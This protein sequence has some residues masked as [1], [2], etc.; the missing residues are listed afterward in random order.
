MTP[1]KQS[2]GGTLMIDRSFPG[3]GRLHRASG[4]TKPASFRAFND[5]LT[6]MGTDPMG[7][8]WIR[9]MQQGT[10]H[11]L[12]VWA[13]YRKNEWQHGPEKAIVGEPLVKAI[14]QW[15]EDTKS[16]VSDDTYRV[17]KELATKVAANSRAG[18]TVGEVVDVMARIKT[19]MLATPASFNILRNYARAFLRDTVGERH[20][21]Y[22]DLKFDV[23]P[24]E[25]PQHALKKERKRHALTPAQVA[26][27]AAAFSTTQPGG[28][29]GAAGHGHVAIGMAITG[30]NPKEYFEAA[31]DQGVVGLRIHGTKRGGRNRMVP[32]LFPSVLWPHATIQRPTITRDSWERTFRAA[33]KKAT[34][35][36]TPMDLRRSFA[37]WMAD[38]GIPQHFRRI[39]RGHG[40]KDMGDL[41]ETPEFARD[42]Q[43]HSVQLTTWLDAQ[44]VAA[45]SAQ[46][47]LQLVAKD[48]AR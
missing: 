42:L 27:L 8:E 15:R 4:L 5:A 16:Q 46:S 24:I 43:A 2:D 32:R 13:A 18:A 17:R 31:W 26:A 9:G 6:I 7:R 45:Q 21:L 14:E 22:Q 39:Y 33:A 35:V 10:V 28:S 38:A 23:K 12:D 44:L 40:P 48:G 1:H 30:M 20:A 19:A 47:G 25:I 41:Y 29:P 34:L 3:I 11:P 36:C 37:N